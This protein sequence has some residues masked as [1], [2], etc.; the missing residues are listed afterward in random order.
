MR[1]VV[2]VMGGDH[3]IEVVIDGAKQA[4][5][6][7]PH[8]SE[9]HLVGQQAE[10]DAGLKRVH[11]ADARLRIHHASEVIT[12]EDKPL[13][14]VRR[15]K[16]CSMVRAMELV[17]DGKAEAVISRGNTGA[18]VASATFKLRRLDSVDRPAIATVIPSGQ[19][20]FV[21]IDA[22]AN[23]E[24]KP[25][26]LVQFAIM[27]SVYSRDVL[28]RPK[29]RVGILSN[30]SEETKGTDLTREA[31]KLCRQTDLN[32][33]GY[34]EGHDLF[35]DHVDVVVTDGFVGNIILK[36]IE[37]MGK[38]II[39]LLRRELTA[40]PVR[41]VGA[42][43]AQGALK[44]IKRR[45]DPEA[46]GGAPLLG[47]N[48]TVIKAHGSAREKAIMNAIRVAGETIQHKINDTIAREVAQANERLGLNKT[49]V[50][51]P[52]PAVA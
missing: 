23:H 45:M 19:G 37:S 51:S 16:D 18:L 38:A 17:R 5:Q 47:L 46:Y 6:A 22:G 48:G 20:E 8:I 39:D 13:D 32:F 40:T 35:A 1:I 41:K 10:I 9:L 28:G 44:S 4:L 43:L 31:A 15:K 14:A 33:I 27:G 24:C 49:A 7:Y 3:G 12:M 34:V 42:V 52:A 36:S 25:V 29:P 11:C 26:H 50:Q 21:L 30:G 2:D